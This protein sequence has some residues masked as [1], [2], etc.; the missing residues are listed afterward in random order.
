MRIAAWS[1]FL[2]SD[3]SRVFKYQK[4]PTKAHK[5]SRLHMKAALNSVCL[6]LFAQGYSFESNDFK[7]LVY[8]FYILCNT[9][10]VILDIGLVYQGVIFEEPV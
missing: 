9:H 8:R 5:K 7:V 1:C 10:F 2:L 4:I 6:E 3:S